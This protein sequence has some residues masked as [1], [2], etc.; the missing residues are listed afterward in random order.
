MCFTTK[1]SH[2]K[3]QPA[4]YDLTGFKVLE[5]RGDLLRSPIQSGTKWTMGK[6]KTASKFEE[7]ASWSSVNQGLHCFNSL[8]NAI[9]GWTNLKTSK[10]EKIFLVTI[11]QGTLVY[12]NDSQY[13]A[14]KMILENVEPVKFKKVP[15]KKK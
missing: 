4:P 6:S 13:C 1:K 2:E 7:Q 5:V 11:P 12:M 15:K 9:K 3:A 10:S 8:Q 14:K